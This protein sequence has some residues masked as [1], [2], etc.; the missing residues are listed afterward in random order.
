M[1]TLDTRRAFREHLAK[2]FLDPEALDPWSGWRAFKDFLRM[3]VEHVY[4]AAAV[5][6]Q[7]EG[8]GPSMFFVR[9][10][11]QRATSSD[12]AEDV[13]LGRLIVE[14][15]YPAHQLQEQEIWT[16]DYPSLEE[17]ASVVE[18]EPTFQTLVNLTPTATEVYYDSGPD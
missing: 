7:L 15:R 14:F 4:D 11:T 10:F 17:W 13:L 2:L 8:D 12:D 5:Q 9:Q 6:F 18:G 1:N 3:E 16:L